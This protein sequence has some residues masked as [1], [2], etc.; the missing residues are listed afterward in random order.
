MGNAHICATTGHQPL[1]QA[2]LDAAEL[3][4]RGANPLVGAIITDD[5]GTVIATGHH[6]GAGTFHAERDAITA[7]YAAGYTDLSSTTL[8]TTLEPCR[9]AGRQPACTELIEAAAIT[10]IICATTDPTANGGGAQLLRQRGA[11]VTVGVLEAEAERLNHRWTLA[12]QQGRPFVTV[13][14]AQSLDARIAAADGTS[15]WITSAASRSHT[16]RIRQRVDAILVGTNTAAVDDP[17]LN[18]RDDDGEPSPHQPLRCV[19]G[20]RPTPAEAQLTA[21]R[22]EGQGW[23]QL[24]TREPLQALRTLAAT[25]HSGHPVRHVLVEGGQSVLSAFFAAGLVDEIFVYTAPLLLGAGRASLADIGVTTLAQGLRCELDTADGGPVTLLDNDV[26]IHLA[27]AG[28][29][30]DH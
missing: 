13:H 7:A 28:P 11:E 14:M 10:T 19:M 5:D 29:K 25:G 30:G 2:A 3:G 23:M 9:H 26:C 12:Q 15:Q 21:G 6:R 24:R 20:L 27:P 1:M 17:R 16:H 8:Y 18:A 22:P 4:H